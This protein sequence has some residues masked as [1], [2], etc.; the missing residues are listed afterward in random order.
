MLNKVGL[1]ENVADISGG[2]GGGGCV[3]VES[4]ARTLSS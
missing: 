1:G 4:D 2:G 3:E